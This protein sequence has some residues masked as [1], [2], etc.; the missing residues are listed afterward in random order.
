MKIVT[1][2]RSAICPRCHVAGLSLKRLLADFPDVEIRQVEFL[3]NRKR[4]REDGVDQIPS[5][6]AGDKKLSGFYLTKKR[7]RGFLESL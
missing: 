1:F 2:Y 4:A 3:T 7:I 6:V 5:F